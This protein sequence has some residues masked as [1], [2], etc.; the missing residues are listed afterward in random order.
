V[1]NHRVLVIG[2]TRGTGKEIVTRLR[3]DGHSVRVLARDA[4]RARALFGQD[5]E[6]CAGDV[7]KRDTLP[8][9]F[10][11]MSD[12]IFTAGV[13]KRPAS[14]RSIIAVEYEGVQNAL[15]AASATAFRGRFLYMTAI[16]VTR[17]SIASIVLNLI[18][19]NTLRWRRR[20]EQEIRRSGID[21]TIVRC[22]VLSNSNVSRA[23][24]LS[25][26]DRRMSLSLRI[27]RGDAA[28][29]FVQ[30][31]GNSNTKRATFD[32]YWSSA[33]AAEPWDRLFAQLHPDTRE[34]AESGQPQ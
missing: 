3:R 22:G 8:G 24:E 11:G 21:Y 27:S 6:V 23:V 14:E 1:P 34:A 12:V 5:V 9:A 10:E 7:T 20:A 32:A 25:Q 4:S 28:E 33:R 19:G 30:A 2:A 15:Y 29:V 16:G 26:R 31:L 18:K 17:H 13:T